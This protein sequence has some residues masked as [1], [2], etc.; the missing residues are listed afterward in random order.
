MLVRILDFGFSILLSL[1]SGIAN[2]AVFSHISP[3]RVKTT[4]IEQQ[5]LKQDLTSNFFE[6]SFDL[7][8]NI[9]FDDLES[10]ITNDFAQGLPSDTEFGSW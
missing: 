3:N 1:G 4:S 5:S 8:N 6:A 7:L 10:I 2:E 9:K